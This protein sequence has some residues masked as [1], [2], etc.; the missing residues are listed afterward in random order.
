MGATGRVRVYPEQ[1]C[2]GCGVVF[3]R[4]WA[5]RVRY[6]SF[7]C[8]RKARASAQKQ[9]TPTPCPRC[10]KN[11]GDRKVCRTCGYALAK[12]KQATDAPKGVSRL[13]KTCRTKRSVADFPV[14]GAYYGGDCADCTYYK[15]LA[16]KYG[17]P[18]AYF[19]ELLQSQ[20][21]LCDIC[22]TPLSRGTRALDHCH[23]TKEPRA[24]LCDPCNLSLG[25]AKDHPT[26]LKNL[27]TYLRTANVATV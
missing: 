1:V 26:T 21:G 23:K 4:K 2:D 15:R 5:S 16:R 13:C 10:G 11:R 25:A 24:F 7:M 17:K 8:A 3:R 22:T 9:Q 14:V 27:T 12:L 18:R 20:Q 6:C 19:I